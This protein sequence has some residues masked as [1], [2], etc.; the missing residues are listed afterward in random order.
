MG[1]MMGLLRKIKFEYLVAGLV[2]IGVCGLGLR[3]WLSTLKKPE[4]VVEPPPVVIVPT[5]TP[6]PTPTPR[7]LTFAEMNQ[8]YG[9]CT[10]LPVLMYHHIQTEDQAK[11]HPGQT[12]L[13]VF[14]PNFREQ[15]Q[16]LKDKNYNVV[17]PKDLVDFFNSGVGIPAKSVMITL[18]DGY[19]DNYTDAFPILREL[20]IKATIFLITG[21]AENP[22]YLTWN[23]VKEMAGNGIYFGNHTWS[24]R[25]MKTNAETIN[26]E[27]GTAQTQLMERGLNP[28]KIFA[29][30]YG[31]MSGTA[32]KYLGTEGYAL[33]FDTIP[34]RILCAKQ[35]YALGRIRVGN[36]KLSNYGL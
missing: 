19:E 29:F 36:G 23:E 34:G 11:A 21:L 32:D 9:P 4:V 14:T 6:S 5:S 17:L 28:E 13:S 35:R 3:L 31:T 30:P 25:N 27:I 10:S 26:K 22:G 8:K 15:M 33:A 16:Y 18:D 1:K 7:P 2:V 20:G 12:N 24:H